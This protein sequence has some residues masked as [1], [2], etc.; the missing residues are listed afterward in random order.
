MRILSLKKY[1]YAY[2]S[3][4]STY[5]YIGFPHRYMIF[6]IRNRVL[7][8]FTENRILRVATVDF[9]SPLMR[10]LGARGLNCIRQDDLSDLSDLSHRQ[11][12]CVLINI[13]FHRKILI[14]K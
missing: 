6:T 11:H 9:S 5:F 1:R 2:I 4:Y 3:F 8:F 7:R 13:L 14:R 12:R 10:I